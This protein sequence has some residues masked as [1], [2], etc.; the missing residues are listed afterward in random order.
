LTAGTVAIYI[1]FPWIAGEPDSAHD[2][3]NPLWVT[4]LSS[5]ALIV[6]LLGV[7][8][9]IAHWIVRRRKK[10]DQPHA[11]DGPQSGSTPAY[12]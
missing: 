1:G 2:D 11:D 4:V 7:A 6:I 12:E 10:N 3:S 5:V 9:L 8:C